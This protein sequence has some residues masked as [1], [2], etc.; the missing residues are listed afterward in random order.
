[1]RMLVHPSKRSS[2]EVLI[3]DAELGRPRL[4]E[5]VVEVNAADQDEHR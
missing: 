3:R 2:T 1:M 5:I 4:D